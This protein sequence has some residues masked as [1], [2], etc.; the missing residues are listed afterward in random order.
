VAGE[1]HIRAF[2]RGDDAGGV[3]DTPVAP[4]ILVLANARP[5]FFFRIFSTQATL[6]AAVVKDPPGTVI[7]GTN[8]N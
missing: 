7:S 1:R 6:V 5:F 4:K 8:A 2:Q 3:T